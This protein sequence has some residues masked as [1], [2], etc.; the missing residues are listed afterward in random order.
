MRK[1]IKKELYKKIFLF[2]K[3]FFNFAAYWNKQTNYFITYILI[4]LKT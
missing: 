2:I 1:S 4:F 3:L